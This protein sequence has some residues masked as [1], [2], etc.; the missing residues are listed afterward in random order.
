[1]G[2]QVSIVAALSSAV[3]FQ[4]EFFGKFSVI[5]VSRGSA[6]VCVV[7]SRRCLSYV[8]VCLRGLGTNQ[9][10][11]LGCQVLLR[12]LTTLILAHGQLKGFRVFS[13]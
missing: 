12:S 7:H 5:T 2:S 11:G 10:E 3:A 6:F 8:I 1:V 13:R 4:Q 9:Q